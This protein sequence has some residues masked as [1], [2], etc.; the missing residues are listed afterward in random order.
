MDI[1]KLCV[2]CFREKGS[3]A[4]CESCGYKAGSSAANELHLSPGTVL[5][6][7]YLVGRVLGYGGFGVTY[8]AYDLNLQQ[9]RAIKEYLPGELST[10]GTDG[11]TVHS[12][13]GEAAENYMYGLEKFIEEGRL[14]AK[15]EGIEAVVSVYDYFREN[16]TAYIVMEFLDGL[17]L[18]AY[19]KTKGGRMS[20]TEAENVFGPIML[21]LEKVHITGMV[22]RDIAPDNIFITNS[23]KVKLLDFGAARQAIGE[24]SE[25][26]SVI[27][28][29]GYAPPEQYHTRGKQGPWTDV[30]ALGATIYRALSGVTPTES[31]TR[32]M[33]DDLRPLSELGVRIPQTAELALAQSLNLDE[34]TR[35]KDMGSFYA[36]LF[37]GVAAPKVKQRA[38]LIGGGESF[39][40]KAKTSVFKPLYIKIT[41]AVLA[42]AMA[43]TLLFAVIMPLINYNTAMAMFEGGDYD[44]SAEGFRKLGDYKDSV[45]LLARSLYKDGEDDYEYGNF[46]DAITPFTELAGTYPEMADLVTDAQYMHGVS[47]GVDGDFDGAIDVLEDV[48]GYMNAGELIAAAEQE[49]A[50]PFM[51][52]VIEHE[53][54]VSEVEVVQTVA[55]Y[56]DYDDDV[57]Q[58]HINDSKP[59]IISITDHPLY[60]RNVQTISAGDKHTIGLKSDGSVIVVGSNTNIM[61][62]YCG[63]CE[64]EDWENIVAISAETCN[65][66]GLK[67]DGT[68][69][70]VGANNKGQCDVDGWE[71][72]V[73]ISSGGWYTVGLQSEG[74]VVAVG[75]NTK[76]QCDVEGWANIVAV[77]ARG[78]HTVGLYADGSVVAVGT[79]EYGQCEVDGWEDIVAVSTGGFHTVGLKSDGTVVAVGENDEGQCEVSSWED[80]VAVS[81]GG[82]HTVGLKSDGSVIAT[83]DN[84]YGCCD[85]VD[86]EDIV[87][88]SSATWITLGLKSDG[89]VL[90]AGSN[91]DWISGYTGRCEVNDWTDIM[92]PPNAIASSNI[93]P[94]QAVQQYPSYE[95]I[96]E[97]LY[98]SEGTD[99]LEHIKDIYG[100]SGDILSIGFDT[101]VYDNNEG[102]EITDFTVNVIILRCENGT[103]E[104]QISD[105]YIDDAI[106]E[107]DSI[108][109][110]EYFA[111]YPGSYCVHG[112]FYLLY[113]DDSDGFIV[114]LPLFHVMSQEFVIDSEEGLSYFSDVIDLDNLSY[115]EIIDFSSALVIGEYEGGTVQVSTSFGASR[116][117]TDV[118]YQPRVEDVTVVAVEEPEQCTE[119]IEEG[120]DIS[121][122]KWLFDAIPSICSDEDLQYIDISE[123]KY[124]SCGH[125]AVLFG[126]ELFQNNYFPVS[127]GVTLLEETI[128]NAFNEL[129]F[130]QFDISVS[131]DFTSVYLVY[132]L[133]NEIDGWET[134]NM[135]WFYLDK[136]IYFYD[137]YELGN[138]DFTPY[139]DEIHYKDVQKYYAY[140]VGEIDG[141][142]VSIYTTE[143]EPGYIARIAIQES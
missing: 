63:Q 101:G 9:V 74:T 103:A 14:L 64:V 41:A 53:L 60:I 30:Y 16:N 10:R 102:G 126:E 89:T 66:V 59:E 109:P 46:D 11:A 45:M 133:D 72:I 71:D 34:N 135:E 69:V 25:S 18:A 83:G 17:D 23:G 111:M 62:E 8:L 105:D 99:D 90:V 21:A 97:V 115:K 95:W 86:W 116:S 108:F 29:P 51:N 142:T 27:L 118:Y 54:P 61:D 73:A 50:E 70:A 136:P 100:V 28:K 75:A 85:L 1:S 49:E 78:D 129:E 31:L 80:I 114:D 4:F 130:D 123:A 139:F 47:L 26:L 141:F 13:S 57:V 134:P 24:K 96:L 112:I 132:L 92:L 2:N 94:T 6:G 32:V 120:V 56:E 5:K 107:L 77:D 106:S 3:G 93:E 48:D 36:S 68:V 88:I 138:I 117:F 140:Y 122:S 76:G 137:T 125:T 65:T 15:F 7:Q 58:G 127:D 52:E 128:G 67:A 12:Y 104:I 43:I 42:T 33:N 79:N 131:S 20:W 121:N 55:E 110:F 39:S 40:Q 22:H 84:A 91:E 119:E 35:F 143:W 82:F 113:D 38:A 37:K 87:A 124:I 98:D 44:G 81:A 19:L